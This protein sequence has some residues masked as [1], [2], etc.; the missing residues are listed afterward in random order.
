MPNSS[1]WLIGAGALALI[2]V[3]IYLMTRGSGGGGG[4]SGAP[5][6]PSGVQLSANASTTGDCADWTATL[7]WSASSSGSSPI[8]YKW[9]FYD[10]SS[11]TGSSCS[12]T[13]VASGTTTSTSVSLDSSQLSAFTQYMV[14]VAATNQWGTASSAPTSVTSGG[15][16]EVDASDVSYMYDSTDDLLL[17]VGLSNTALPADG[18]AATLEVNGDS[19][20]STTTTYADQ[21][22]ALVAYAMQMVDGDTQ[23]LGLSLVSNGGTPIVNYSPE[24]NNTWSYQFIQ[25]TSSGTLSSD[26]MLDAS[27]DASPV[28]L[29][30]GS[31]SQDGSTL[32]VTQSS[33][34]GQ[35]TIATIGV[36]SNGMLCPSSSASCGS[37]TPAG[38]FGV[39][40]TDVPALSAGDVL[41]VSISGGNSWTG[42][43]DAD[44][45]PYT[46]PGTAPSAPGSIALSPQ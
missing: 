34:I 20:A 15:G 36:T 30:A 45:P 40:F 3:F 28:A 6:A 18:F 17:V 26:Q 24:A 22:V 21:T 31:S 33:N 38:S 12:G 2:A 19:A 13:P 43:C 42:S 4:G 23:T 5:G 11:C 7:S 14:V 46:L 9:S 39:I 25:H 35:S 37:P 1:Y 10:P 16:F 29:I 41:T 44:L 32:V 27:E 8:T